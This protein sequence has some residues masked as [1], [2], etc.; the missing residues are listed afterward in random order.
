MVL[1]LSFE[2]PS[3]P[4][5]IPP[6]DLSWVPDSPLPNPMGLLGEVQFPMVTPRAVWLPRRP[7]LMLVPKVLRPVP[8]L[9]PPAMIE[10]PTVQSRLAP[11]IMARI[12]PQPPVTGVTRLEHP[13]L[14]RRAP[15]LQVMARLNLPVR[16]VPVVLLP[17][18]SMVVRLPAGTV[19]AP[20]PMSANLPY[21]LFGYPTLVWS[22]RVY[23]LTWGLHGN[24]MRRAQ[25]LLPPPLI[26][27]QPLL[28]P[29]FRRHPVVFV[30]LLFLNMT[31]G[32]IPTMVPV[33]KHPI[34]N[35]MPTLVVMTLPPSA[36]TLG[37]MARPTLLW[38]PVTPPK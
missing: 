12:P 8:P 7:V 35:A 15:R 1:I 21:P 17:L 19:L 33:P 11:L 3:S 23:P 18:V 31:M 6:F 13:R 38:P 16:V 29:E 28:I 24:L 27:A 4:V 36:R 26:M 30:I 9:P 37:A 34:G 32:A 14:P 2:L 25:S 20:R 5:M 10:E 22:R